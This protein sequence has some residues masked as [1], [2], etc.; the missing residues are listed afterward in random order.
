MPPRLT[1]DDGRFVVI[2]PLAYAAESDLAT[3]AEQR[4]FP[5]LPCRLCGSQE[6]AQ[7]KQMKALLNELERKH[8]TLRQT[9]LAALGNV[10]PS[11]LYD[12]KLQSGLG[13][14]PGAAGDAVVID[15]DL[16]PRQALRRA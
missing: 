4:K 12:R 1:T 3:F 15:S 13:P 2:R 9:M 8:P 14:T 11:H 6:N 5:I 7:R 16:I 10:N